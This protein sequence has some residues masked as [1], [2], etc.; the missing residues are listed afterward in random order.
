MQGGIG[1]ETHPRTRGKI[2]SKARIPNYHH[3]AQAELR[4]YEPQE[5][6]PYHEQIRSARKDTKKESIQINTKS[7]PRAPNCPEYTE[8]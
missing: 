1:F 6:T 3:E 8:S 2:P 7:N 4:G 5:G